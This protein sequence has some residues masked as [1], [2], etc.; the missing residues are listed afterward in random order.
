MKIRSIAPVASLALFIVLGSP[1]SG[2]SEEPGNRNPGFR[3][4]SGEAEAGQEAFVRLNCTRCHTVAGVELPDPKGT[5]P[6]E[7]TLAAESRFVKD[8][9]DLVIAITNPRHVIRENYRAI[10]DEAERAGGIEP[11]MPD[12]T[13]DM[14]ARQLMDL[15]AFLD[16]V[17][18]RELE[19]YG[20]AGETE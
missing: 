12:L 17:Y 4:P 14:S 6:L 18:G 16:D 15:V 2:R 10:L 13:R 20:D 8:Y 11:F 3:F 1:N 5:R 9:P 7:L 19:G